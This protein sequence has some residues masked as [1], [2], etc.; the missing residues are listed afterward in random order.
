MS[1]ILN[2]ASGSGDPATSLSA[3]WAYVQP[4]LDHIVKSPSNDPNGKAPAIDFG[5]YTGIHSACYNYFTSAQHEAMSLDASDDRAA[6]R[7]KDIYA[8]LDKYFEEV[9]RELTLGA[10]L[11]DITLIQYLVPSFNRY[12][13]GAFA[14]NRLL[15]Y[16][17]RHYVKRAMD[18]DNGWFRMADVLKAMGPDEQ[19]HRFNITK[20]YQEKKLEELQ[21]WGYKEG[22]SSE[23]L[24]F[25]ESCAEAGSP[26]DR[27]VPVASTAHRRFRTEFLEPLLATPKIKGTTRNKNKIPKAPTTPNP[28]RPKGRLARAIHELLETDA[29]GP[30]ERLR[31]A[32]DLAKALQVTG[33]KEDHPLRKKLDKFLASSVSPI[34]PSD[35]TL[36]R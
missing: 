31:L 15:N 24:A 34:P 3:L 12:H 8:R 10:P 16:V 14:A 21:Q 33:V 25:A 32:R 20:R 17:N 4:A 11:D 26:L 29:V 30:E 7:G 5:L 28:A 18:E 13:A 22:D 19:E 35:T 2:H 1:T 6:A 36:R 9:A 27:V 23:Q